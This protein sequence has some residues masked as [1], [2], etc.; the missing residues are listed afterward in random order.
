MSIEDDSALVARARL[1]DGS[2]FTALV[3]R[4]LRAA[5]A[6]GLAVLHNSAEAEDL[7]QE[8]FVIA[9]QSLATCRDPARFVSWLFS[10][11][12]NRG[13]NRLQQQRVRAEKDVVEREAVAFS[14]AERVAVK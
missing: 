11:V 3:R 9:W 4:H 12:R 6:V 1:G 2:A 14:D 13:L 5:I 7:A 8:A 10:I